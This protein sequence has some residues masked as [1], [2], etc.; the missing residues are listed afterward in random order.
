MFIEQPHLPGPGSHTVP[1][2]MGL[3]PGRGP[4]GRLGVG[5]WGSGSCKGCKKLHLGQRLEDVRNEN[6]LT[7][8]ALSLFVQRS[9]EPFIPCFIL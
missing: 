8:E 5:E 7:G 9:T 3:H 6:I 4:V 1:A 2:L